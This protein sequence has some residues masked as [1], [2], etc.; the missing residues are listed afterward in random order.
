MSNP[1]LS[2]Q[3]VRAHVLSLRDELIRNL[4]FI[5]S[6]IEQDRLEMEKYFRQFR[7]LRYRPVVA[8]DVDGNP[9]EYGSPTEV[10][11]EPLAVQF[12][13]TVKSL[14]DSIRV[15][16]SEILPED[17]PE[18]RDAGVNPSESAA[19]RRAALR[20]DFQ[21]PQSTPD[22]PKPVDVEV[23]RTP[24]PIAESKPIVNDQPAPRPWRET[25]P[26]SVSPEPVPAKPETPP[27]VAPPKAPQPG[28]IGLSPAL[29]AQLAGSAPGRSMDAMRDKYKP[30]DKK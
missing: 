2:S 3:D 14:L 22:A 29:R 26:K 17:N 24:K 11:R 23:S 18:G 13:T 20:A 27:V 12:R 5:Q 4:K 21:A 25:V 8:R 1:S 28:A 9:T 10:V 16:E 6:C 7:D 30:K 15:I 19:R